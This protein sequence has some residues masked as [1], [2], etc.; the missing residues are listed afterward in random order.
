MPFAKGQS[1][2]PGGYSQAR[3]LLNDAFLRALHRVWNEHGEMALKRMAKEYPAQFVA[4]MFKLLP[5]ETE[6][7]TDNT[8]EYEPL[9]ATLGWLDE[10]VGREEDQEVSELRS[11]DRANSR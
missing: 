4:H 1:G 2:N 3:K 9:T 7:E 8:L 6:I 10:I 5:K 11:R